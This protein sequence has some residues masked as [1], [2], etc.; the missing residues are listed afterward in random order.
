MNDKYNEKNT[1]YIKTILYICNETKIKDMYKV[2]N[3]QDKGFEYLNQLLTSALD[4]MNRSKSKLEL[5]QFE[6]LSMRLPQGYIGRSI[7]STRTNILLDFEQR[8]RAYNRINK[9]NLDL[10]T[11]ISTQSCMNVLKYLDFKIITFDRL[12][13]YRK[14]GNYKNNKKVK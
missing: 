1:L 7:H 3:L 6:E 14:L 2:S 9:E 10:Y 11:F 5:S 13:N 12:E 4:Q 8:R